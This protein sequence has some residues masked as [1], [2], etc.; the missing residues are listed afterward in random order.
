MFQLHVR[1]QVPTSIT[2]RPCTKL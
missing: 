1:V 2:I